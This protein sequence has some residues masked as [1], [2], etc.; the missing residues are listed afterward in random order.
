M[1][2]YYQHKKI[3]TKFFKL[4]GTII[5][6]P[7]AIKIVSA[8]LVIFMVPQYCAKQGLPVYFR[9]ASFVGFVV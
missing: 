6:F 9:Y 1:Y 8:S 5:S 7:L 3:L 2:F 4:Q